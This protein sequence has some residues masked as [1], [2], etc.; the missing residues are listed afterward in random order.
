[1]IAIESYGDTYKVAAC[2]KY[3]CRI[4]VPEFGKK[5]HQ[6]NFKQD[7]KFIWFSDTAFE[8]KINGKNTRFYQCET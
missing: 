2:A 7:P 4:A 8:T 6:G 1:M 3:G 5:T